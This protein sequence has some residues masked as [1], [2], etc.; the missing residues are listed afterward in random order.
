MIE[1]KTLKNLRKENLKTPFILM[2]DKIRKEAINTI[3]S[4]D[5][6][7]VEVIEMWKPILPKNLEIV[8]SLMSIKAFLIYWANLNEGDLK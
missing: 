8:P 3:K 6:S 7:S 1:V 2:E 4:M 5:L